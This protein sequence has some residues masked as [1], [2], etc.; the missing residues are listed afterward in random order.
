MCLTLFS[1]LHKTGEAL[2]PALAELPEPTL[3]RPLAFTA[4][5]RPLDPNHAMDGF[6]KRYNKVNVKMEIF[7]FLKKAYYFLFERC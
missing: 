2:P 7:L 6:W 3:L 4:E 1:F 5:N